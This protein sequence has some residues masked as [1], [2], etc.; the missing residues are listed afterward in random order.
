MFEE[1]R[2][3]SAREVALLLGANPRAAQLR[4]R[5][6]FRSGEIWPYASSPVPLSPWPGGGERYWLSPSS[7]IGRALGFERSKWSVIRG[8]SSAA[9]TLCMKWRN[10]GRLLNRTKLWSPTTS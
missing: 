7:R 8:A 1:E 4:A 9:A 10:K 5:R 2:R 3:L 6:A